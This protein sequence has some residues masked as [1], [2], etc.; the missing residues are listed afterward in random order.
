MLKR[1]MLSLVVAALGIGV[2]A[3]MWWTG[4]PS[5]LAREDPGCSERDADGPFMGMADPDAP[6]DL[7]F[8]DE[9]I[10]HHQGAIMSAGMM[11]ADSERPEL[12]D[13]TR[14]IQ[15]SQQRQIDQ[16]R[17]WRAQW[18]PD[19]P[20]PAMDMEPTANMMGGRMSGDGMMDGGGMMGMMSG[21]MMGGDRTD[22]MFLQMMIPHHQLAVEMG[23]DALQNAEHQELK[24]LADE[25]I[26]GQSAEITEMERY[27]QDWY[28]AASTRDAASGMQ[29]MMG[30]C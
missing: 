2:V 26:Q 3:G 17:E 8:I 28:G 21:G 6:Y 22:K 5:V 11:I 7:R 30:Q 27:L 23:E 10:M 1:M 24:G 18:Y 19:A 4:G 14:R 29:S 13:L 20:A 12:R 25:I 16:M 9:M 15:E